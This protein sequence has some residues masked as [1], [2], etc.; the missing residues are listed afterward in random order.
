LN[1]G[2]KL[3]QLFSLEG[4]TI[5][6]T[7]AAGGI[8]EVLAAGLAQAGGDMQLC[9]IAEDRL[10]AVCANIT[11]QGC[12]ASAYPMDMSDMASIKECVEKA[13]ADKGRID[14]LIN[15]AGINK[16]DGF[17]DV[18]EELY[19][20]IMAVNLKGVYFLSQ[21]VAKHMIKEKNG[22]IIN[23]SSHNAVGMLGGC[24]VYGAAKSAV[25]AL[26]RSMAVEWAQ[27]GIRANALA[28]GHILTPLTQ[29]T[30]DNPERVDYLT[31]RIAMRRPGTPEE[32]VGVTVMLASDASSYMSGMMIH[33]DGGC[34]AGGS[35]WPYDTKY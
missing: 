32:L 21:E 23:I 2:Q 30:W 7:G 12:S 31:P 1:I 34:L 25:T 29:V 11:E 26:T 28:P 16:R 4:K 3:T 8:G 27:Y 24:S 17:L 13:V 6:L 10:A 22:N 14:V 9:D 15:C 20:K 35:P 19:D 33:V 18:T 5:L